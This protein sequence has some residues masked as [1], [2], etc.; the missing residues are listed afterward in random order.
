M[1]PLRRRDGGS[2]KCGA[3]AETKQFKAGMTA[4]SPCGSTGV[5]VLKAGGAEVSCA[6]LCFEGECSDR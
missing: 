4:E 6:S 2:S 3:A 1:R 5:M